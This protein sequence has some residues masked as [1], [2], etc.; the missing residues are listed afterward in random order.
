M[1]FYEDFNEK[2]DDLYTKDYVYKFPL[3]FKVDGND[4][5]FM[6]YISKFYFV[7][8]R[9]GVYLDNEFKFRY[10]RDNKAGAILLLPEKAELQLDYEPKIFDVPSRILAFKSRAAILPGFTIG[11]AGK[12]Y[13]HDFEAELQSKISLIPEMGHTVKLMHDGLQLVPKVGISSLYN[14]KPLLLGFDYVFDKDA[15]NMSGPLELLLGVSPYPRVLTYLKHQVKQFKYP[16]RIGLGLYFQESYAVISDKRTKN[17][18]YRQ[19]NSKER[20]G[21][22]RKYYSWPFEFSV[23]GFVDTLKAKPVRG[24]NGRASGVLEAERVQSKTRQ[25]LQVRRRVLPY[26]DEGLQ[27]YLVQPARPAETLH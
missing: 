1:L 18:S 8:K 27:I 9:V 26:P 7:S 24:E 3:Q 20:S 4:K 25:R 22:D 14:Q 2:I 15:K 16:G 10:A 17:P 11:T 21:A 12:K 23:E 13:V 5:E 6:S 19:Q